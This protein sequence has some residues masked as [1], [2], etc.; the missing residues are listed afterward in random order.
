MID[1]YDQGYEDAVAGFELGD[2][3]YER[4]T[5]AYEMYKQGMLAAEF[6]Y[7]E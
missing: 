3:P 7:G 4:G 5:D 1:P 6:D 2:N